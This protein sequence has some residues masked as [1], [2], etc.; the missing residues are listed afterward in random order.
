MCVHMIIIIMY[1]SEHNAL[2]HTYC[3][4]GLHTIYTCTT[5]VMKVLWQFNQLT[6]GQV[7]VGGHSTMAVG[8]PQ[9]SGCGGSQHNGCGGPQLSKGEQVH[10]AK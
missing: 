5:S 8:G 6:S 3:H 1:N 4:G 9:H 2:V 7:A 10:V